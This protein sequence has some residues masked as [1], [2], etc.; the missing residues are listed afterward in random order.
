MKYE[1]ESID[2]DWLNSNDNTLN[3]FWLGNKQKN[4]LNIN[5]FPVNLYVLFDRLFNQWKITYKI[6]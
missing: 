4:R 6:K 1:I 3:W 5:G 2:F